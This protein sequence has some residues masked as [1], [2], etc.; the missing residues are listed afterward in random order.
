M[1]DATVSLF[2]PHI[3]AVG[4]AVSIQPCAVVEPIRVHDE[5]NLGTQVHFN[6]LWTSLERS[7][8]FCNTKS[9]EFDT[10]QAPCSRAPFDLLKGY[11][12]LP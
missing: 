12:S 7:G 1:I 3:G 9:L 5:K 4:M 2:D 6:V 10:R 11:Q 8:T